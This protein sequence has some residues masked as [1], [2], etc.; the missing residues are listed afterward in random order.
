MKI[1]NIETLLDI[2]NNS[3]PSKWELDTI[4]WADRTTDPKV[5]TAFLKRIDALS[6]EA[7]VKRDKQEL[8]I[9]T[10][11][12]EE[13]DE[14]ECKNLLTQSDED[15]KNSFIERLAR[16]GAI[17]V[18]TNQKLSYDTMATTCKLSPSDFILC[19]KRT[20]DL[21]DSIS[22]LAIKGETLSKDVAG[23]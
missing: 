7:I 20:Q 14:D 1:E 21:I 22:A 16:H 9:L 2:T 6:K 23:A 17:E 18:I 19:A 5:L 11:L 8:A 13:M 3:C 10:E 12:L 4:V 15:A